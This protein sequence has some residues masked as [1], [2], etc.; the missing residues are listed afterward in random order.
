LKWREREAEYLP[1]IHAAGIRAAAQRL[2]K[3]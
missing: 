2:S 1:A 3:E